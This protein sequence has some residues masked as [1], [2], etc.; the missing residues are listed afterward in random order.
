MR[1]FIFKKRKKALQQKTD[2]KFIEKVLINRDQ[3][4]ILRKN[5]SFQIK[6]KQN[7]FSPLISVFLLH[8]LINDVL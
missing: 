8:L 2:D 1:N 6:K 4:T 5:Y 7:K 3:S